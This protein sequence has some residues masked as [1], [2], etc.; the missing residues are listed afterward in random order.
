M[1]NLIESPPD[2]PVK[3]P[4]TF[5][6]TFSYR[7]E[8]WGSPRRVVAKMEW[9]PGELFPRLG[10]I[11]TNL[12]WSSSNVIKFYNGRGTADQRREARAQLDTALLS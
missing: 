6:A 9:H 7:A 2:P 5:Y 8:S 3:E 11:V 1:K 4:I 10:F 12:T